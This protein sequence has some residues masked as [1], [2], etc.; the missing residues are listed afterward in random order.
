MSIKSN[1]EYRVTTIRIDRP[2]ARNAVDPVT[3]TA[4]YRAM[5]DFESD[6]KADIAILTGDETAF[7]AGFDLKAAAHGLDQ[8]WLD[9]HDISNDWHDP[10]AHP[11]PSPMGPARLM[12]SKP[13]IAAIEGAAV[14][15]GMELAL[16]CDIRIV[17]RSAYF[18][19]YCRRWGVPLIDG[20]TFR[21][22]HAIGTG[23]ARD[24]ILTG[25]KV[26]ASEAHTIGLA[27]RLCPDGAALET[28]RAYAS[29]LLRFPQA[30]MRAD[31]KSSQGAP[32]NLAADLRREWQSAALIAGESLRGATRFA[33][34]KGRGGDFSKI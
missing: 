15:G 6:E 22:P 9:R 7:C 25:R 1:T 2:Q 14:A 23:R 27:N 33:D 17:A 10:V 34:G 8:G 19:I 12:L 31:R 13:V 20:G 26:E 5:L 24:L 29:D 3:A 30:C 11:L 18:G 4:L 28:A 16:W 21:L 32:A